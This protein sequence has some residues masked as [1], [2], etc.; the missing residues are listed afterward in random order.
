[1]NTNLLR[2]AGYAVWLVSAGCATVGPDFEQPE[3]QVADTWLEAGDPK[4]DT[5]QIAYQDW[6]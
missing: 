4:V 1:M 2:V 5:T 6:W 3:V